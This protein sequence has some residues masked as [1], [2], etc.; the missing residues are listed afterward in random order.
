MTRTRLDAT[1]PV[2]AA[3]GKKYKQCCLKAQ[4]AITREDHLWHSM[5]QVTEGL[6]AELLKFAN[7]QF[8]LAALTEAWNEF[9]PWDG[10]RFTPDTPH[11]QAFMP[12]FL[13]DW[14]PYQQPAAG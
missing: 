12:W 1:T 13:Y 11:M 9:M 2:R 8:G 3:A 6:P 4:E 14:S 7:A 10:E 5:R